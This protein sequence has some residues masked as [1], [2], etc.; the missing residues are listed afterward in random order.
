M[1][2]ISKSTIDES[3]TLKTM[4]LSFIEEYR[5][6]YRHV[7]LNFDKIVFLAC[8]DAEKPLEIYE[9]EDLMK[10]VF[11]SHKYIIVGDDRLRFMNKKKLMWEI[12]HI[13]CHIPAN[14]SGL[15]LKHEHEIFLKQY[16]VFQRSDNRIYKTQGEFEEPDEKG[17]KKLKQDFFTDPLVDL[18]EVEK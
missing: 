14:F 11:P 16:E 5:N 2:K 4:F 18:R 17:L 6:E 7:Y 15:L 3:L 12:T 1:P 13:L 10:V 9:I 8:K